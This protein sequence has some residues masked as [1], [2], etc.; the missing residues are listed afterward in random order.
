MATPLL[1]TSRQRRQSKQRRPRRFVGA[2]AAIAAGALLGGS[3]VG[4]L[5]AA[6]RTL[7]GKD[8]SPS[9]GA[10]PYHLPSHSSAP[11]PLAASS[12]DPSLGRRG[13]SVGRQALPD[14]NLAAWFATQLAEMPDHVAEYG[15]YGPLYF[16]GMAAVAEALTFP[17]TPMMLTSGYIFGL[18]LGV[19]AMLVSMSCA[20]SLHFMLSRTLLRP[21]IE[22]LVAENK[23]AQSINKAVEREGF[24]I[25]FL[26]RLEPLLPSSIANFAFGL[27]GTSYAEF[28]GATLLGYIPYTLAL[29]SSATVLKGVFSE[30]V[31]YPWYV[32]AVGGSLYLGLLW[33]ITDVAS[34]AIS[35]AIREDE[36]ADDLRAGEGD[37]LPR[38]AVASGDSIG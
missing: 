31:E 29:V 21:S 26:L 8:S 19:S 6:P 37:Q 11:M 34:R 20:A 24:K 1:A 27:S 18:P 3:C 22:K 36:E 4:F 17:V 5:V 7:A 30:G 2:S 25:M 9:A 14:A 16:M 23:K 10:A 13:G 12:R 15:P 35:E 28:L 38:M 33:L 32:Y